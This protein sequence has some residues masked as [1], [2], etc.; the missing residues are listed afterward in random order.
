MEFRVLHYTDMND[1]WLFSVS[2][3]CLKSSCL[4]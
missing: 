1:M 3:L 4:H 2:H